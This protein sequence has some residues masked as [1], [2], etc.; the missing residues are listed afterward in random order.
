MDTGIFMPTLLLCGFCKH[1]NRET[2]R[3]CKAFPNGIPDDIRVN[4][5]DHHKPYPGDNGILFE[6]T[7]DYEGRKH[8]I[9]FR[10]KP[11]WED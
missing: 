5:H 10:V 8:L 4:Y 9:E 3:S 2:H 1:L 7:D 6:P 11:D